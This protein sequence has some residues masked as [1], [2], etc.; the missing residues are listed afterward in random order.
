MGVKE[1]IF[2]YDI[3]VKMFWTLVGILSL[4]LFVYVY[5]VLGTINNN[6]ARENL[7]KESSALSARVSELEFEDIALRNTY[8]LETALARGFKEVKNPVYVSRSNVS[9]TLNTN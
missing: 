2:S 4:S 9:L 3:R 1:K 6:V 7:I 8:D 5:A